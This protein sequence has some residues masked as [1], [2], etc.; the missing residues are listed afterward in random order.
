MEL[1][2]NDGN[3]NWIDTSKITNMSGLFR[4][5]GQI[6]EEFNGDIS[7]WDVSNV[8]DMH[9]MFYN[10]SIFDRDISLWDTKSVVTMR[11]MFGQSIFN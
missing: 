5:P 11:D 2:G 9:G 6:K 8:T 10:N 3:F 1:L 7:L 4:S